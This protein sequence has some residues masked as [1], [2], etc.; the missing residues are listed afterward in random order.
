MQDNCSIYL[1][2]KISKGHEDNTEAYWSEQD[3]ASMTQHLAPMQVNLLNPAHRSDDITN[4]KSV[5]GRDM[6]QVF[7]SDVVWVDARDRR[8]LGVGAEMMWAKMKHI[9]LIALSPKETFYRKSN[10]VLLGKPIAQYTHPFIEELCDAV[11]GSIEEGAQ[12]IKEYLSGSSSHTNK[13]GNHIV[14][15]MQYYLEHQFNQDTPM[16][17]MSTKDKRLNDKLL[18]VLKGKL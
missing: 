5:F 10:A 17:E 16:V 7:C 4:M 13:D 15:C 2:G 14:E 12:W 18:S 8:G 11:V 6:A 3:L 1:A 9:P